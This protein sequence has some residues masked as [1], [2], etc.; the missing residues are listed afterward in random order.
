[1]VERPLKDLARSYSDSES[2]HLS[3]SDNEYLLT[4]EAN[5]D[6]PNDRQ[7]LSGEE[8]LSCTSRVYGFALEPKQRS[9]FR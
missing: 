3:G 5:D 4:N 2:V 7:E 8:L 9:K 1:M 6:R